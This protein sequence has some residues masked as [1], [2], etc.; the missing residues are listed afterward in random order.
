MS[1][2]L[3]DLA[4]NIPWLIAEMKSCSSSTSIY[5]T[6]DAMFL[7]V[8]C[9]IVVCLAEVLQGGLPISFITPASESCLNDN[10]SLVEINRIN[11]RS[12]DG[13]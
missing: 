10:Y 7:H 9:E 2:K 6:F 4:G 3:S 1:S 12:H 13:T 8:G 11:K 5:L